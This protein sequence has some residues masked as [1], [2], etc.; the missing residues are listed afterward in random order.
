MKI[1]LLIILLLPLF[2]CT[3]FMFEESEEINKSILIK[4]PFIINLNNNQ[5]Y[6]LE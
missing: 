3:H 1:F 4:K 5:K 2:A 6:S